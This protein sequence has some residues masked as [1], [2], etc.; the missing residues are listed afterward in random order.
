ME[1]IDSQIRLLLFF[2]KNLIAIIISLVIMG[3]IALLILKLIEYFF[4]LLFIGGIIAFVLEVS[5]NQK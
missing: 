4:L 1:R 5:S 2:Q 3:F